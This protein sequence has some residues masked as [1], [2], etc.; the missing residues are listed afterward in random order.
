LVSIGVTKRAIEV[1]PIR[2]A[3]ISFSLQ[4][5]KF[6]TSGLFLLGERGEAIL[7]ETRKL[8]EKNRLAPL[9]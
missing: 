5:A 8:F 4:A 2:R 6:V 3:T 1:E 9:A 7:R